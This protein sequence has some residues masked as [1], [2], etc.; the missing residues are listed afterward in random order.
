MAENNT[1][2]VSITK[3]V[4]G[5][6]CF[7]APLGTTLPT[8]ATTALNQAFVNVG[9]LDDSGIVHSKSVQTTNFYDL[10]GDNIETASSQFERTL[11][12]RFA[13]MN[14]VAL[15]EQYGDD[16]V[17]VDSQT[18]AIT[19]NDNN[20]KMPHKAMVLELV[21]KDER[22]YRR[23][24]PDLAVTAWGDQTDVSNQL[25]GGEVTYNKYADSSGNYEY[26]YIE[27]E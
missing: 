5:G 19:I 25:A 11:K 27:G 7:V 16:N 24:F 4:V 23:V 14:P 1:A 2:N 12:L 26:G 3:G 18:G 17:E 20:G 8:D 15:K 6:Y 13:E 9:Y 22:H 21:L 10:N